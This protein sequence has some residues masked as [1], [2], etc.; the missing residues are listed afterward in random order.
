MLPHPGRSIRSGSPG[1]TR[2]TDTAAMS[3]PQPAS[4]SPPT[5]AARSAPLAGVRVLDLTRVL[6]GP[7]STQILADLGADVIKV[8]RPRSG[9]HPGGDD[10]RGWGPPFLRGRDGQDTAEAAYYLEIG[11]AHV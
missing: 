10:T 9:S 1:H 7:W 5:P 6:A 2:A 8:E 11:R 4:Q 3:A